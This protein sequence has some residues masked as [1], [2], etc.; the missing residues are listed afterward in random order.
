M[1]LTYTAGSIV[2]VAGVTM[3]MNGGR[4]EKYIAWV[5]KGAPRPD[6]PL[7][8]PIKITYK[9]GIPLWPGRVIKLDD[10]Y[11]Q[12]NDVKAW[13]Y[14]LKKRGWTIDM[15]ALYGPKSTAVC[16]LF[17]KKVGLEPT[18]VID[19]ESWNITWSWKPPA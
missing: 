8:K 17:Q 18:G 13:Q 15:D 1:T 12:G 10:P 9:D 2:R 7:E 16:K 6:K 4:G 11:M 14:K 5:K 19:E 3:H